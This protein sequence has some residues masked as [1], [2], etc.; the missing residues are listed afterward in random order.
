MTRR[1]YDF[2]GVGIELS[3]DDEALLAAI[4]GRLSSFRTANPVSDPLLL[5][6][7]LTSTDD[8]IALA[9]PDGD[10]RSVYDPPAG[11]VSYFPRSDELYVD[12]ESRVRSLCRAREGTLEVRAGP[13]EHGNLWLL[14]RPLLT[15]PLIELLKRRGL[16]SVHAAAVARN[17]NALLLPGST[18][19]GKT[20]LAVALA[21]DGFQLLA[22]DMVFLDGSGRT[23]HGFPDELDLSE[24]TVRAFPHLKTMTSLEQGW[25]KR[26]LPPSRAFPVIEKAPAVSALVFPR[27]SPDA[28]PQLSTLAPGEA[29]QRLVANV[30]LTEQVSS[31]AHLAALGV[32]AESCPSYSLETGGDPARAAAAVAALT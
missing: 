23:V 26:R 4:D 30:L 12:Y 17:G 22:D 29:L 5:S 19:A 16:Y 8:V 21:S 15:L 25:P 20:T 18:G 7:R 3:V 11:E 6:Y 1:R 2:H 10:G 32:L 28:D 13:S 31:G 27:V 9:R 14:S 24:E